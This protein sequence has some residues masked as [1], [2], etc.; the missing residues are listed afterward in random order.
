MPTARTE[1][2]GEAT[3]CLDTHSLA[4]RGEAAAKHEIAALAE[5]IVTLG[6]GGDLVAARVVAAVLEEMRPQLAAALARTSRCSPR[7]SPWSWG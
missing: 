5:R 7:R 1:L 3:G 6:L 2:F 4:A